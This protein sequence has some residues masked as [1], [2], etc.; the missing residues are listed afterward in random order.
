MEAIAAAEGTC[1]QTAKV[2]RAERIL[3][4]FED[5]DNACGN[6]RTAIY[7]STAAIPS[8]A[9]Y[10]N[11]DLSFMLQVIPS[12]ASDNDILSASKKSN[13]N[14]FIVISG[15][16]IFD[17]SAYPY[18]VIQNVV[19][20]KCVDFLQSLAVYIASFSIF[21]YWYTNEV[22]C[23]I[24]FIQ[25][26]LLNLNPERGSKVIKRFSGNANAKVVKLSNELQT[27]TSPW[28]LGIQ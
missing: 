20:V 28:A 10:F 3:K 11:E 22:K 4:T 21:G 9:N 14:P 27:F 24:E 25:S 6:E 5:P 23:T 8:V 15:D 7:L 12:G 13:G 1:N 2:K 19:I 17:E 16:G 26:F 18:L